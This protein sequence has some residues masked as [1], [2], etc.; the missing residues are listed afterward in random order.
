MQGQEIFESGLSDK[1]EAVQEQNTIG[2]SSVADKQEVVQEQNENRQSNV[3]DDDET[4]DQGEP[5]ERPTLVVTLKVAA[6]QERNDAQRSVASADLRK[7]QQDIVLLDGVEPEEYTVMD[8]GTSDLS[9][10][11][12][13]TS[14]RTLDFVEDLL[15]P[16]Q[17]LPMD[18][19]YQTIADAWDSRS[20]HEE[21][22]ESPA[23]V[24]PVL[25]DVFGE[26]SVPMTSEQASETLP[27]NRPSLDH[28][29][30][31]QTQEGGDGELPLDALRS[32]QDPYMGQPQVK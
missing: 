6:P 10:G 2:Q 19:D 22:Q 17:T 5:T 13:I 23:T 26:W 20:G 29:L 9:L 14:R 8:D 16:L 21:P 30:H 7:E 28:P 31:V 27:W 4:D 15:T 24:S 18:I 12:P 25:Q 1:E 3:V 32:P 11:D